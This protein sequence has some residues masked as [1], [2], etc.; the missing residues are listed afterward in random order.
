MRKQ[1]LLAALVVIVAVAVPR[2]LSAGSVSLD[3]VV[4]LEA[5]T[6]DMFAATVELSS[7]LDASAVFTYG[8]TFDQ[9]GW[10]GT[11]GGT[12]EGLPVSG[13]TAGSITGDPYTISGDT[14]YYGKNGKEQSFLDQHDLDADQYEATAVHAAKRCLDRQVY[15]H[16]P[17]TVHRDDKRQ[18]PLPERNR[19]DDVYGFTGPVQGRDQDQHEKGYLHIVIQANGGP[20]AR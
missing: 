4:A 12:Y 14:E 1:M 19:E 8:G 11:F 20:D 2:P 10:S 3:T 13:T 7:G 6:T 9:T 15:V 16:Q 18:P 17:E 5:L